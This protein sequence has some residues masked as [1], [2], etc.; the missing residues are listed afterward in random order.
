[1][2]AKRLN[3]SMIDRIAFDDLDGTL[4]VRFRNGRRYFYSG[5]PADMFEAMCTAVSPG[6]YLNANVRGR[7]VCR[8]DPA[9]ARFRPGFEDQPPAALSR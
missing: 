1:M 4:A 9:Q 2:R 6:R 8:P 7:F 5:V 3:S